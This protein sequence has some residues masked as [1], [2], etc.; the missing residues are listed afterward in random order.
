MYGRCIQ[1]YWRVDVV[2][3][4]FL[5]CHHPKRKSL[6][7]ST[8]PG[9]TSVSPYLCSTCPIHS[10]CV[11]PSLSCPMSCRCCCPCCSAC[12]WTSCCYSWSDCWQSSSC[13]GYWLSPM[14]SWCSSTA[15]DCWWCCCGQRVGTVATVCSCYSSCCCWGSLREGRGRHPAQEE[16]ERATDG[17][18]SE[19]CGREIVTN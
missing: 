7:W 1:M 11:P 19:T 15:C 4:T 14:S 12:H 10:S 16:R 2:I 9:W 13:S 6:A 17:I 3:A 18:C 8:H 5:P